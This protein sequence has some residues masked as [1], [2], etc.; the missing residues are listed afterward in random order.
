MNNFVI[1]TDSSSNITEE[2]LKEYDIKMLPYIITI[3]G[4][5]FLC[6]EEGMDFEASVKNLYDSIKGGAKV[7][8]TLINGERFCDFVEPYLKEGKDVLFLSMSSGV[9]GTYNAV[10]HACE[11]LSL[12]Y[13]D[14]KCVA[15]DTLAASLGEGLLVLRAAELKKDGKSLN[16]IVAIV[17]EE[18]KSIRQV[19]TVD[20]LK[21]LMNGGR[22]SR[23]TAVVGT[24]LHIKPVL[25]GD[26]GK[27]VSHSKVKG[28]KKALDSLVEDFIRTAI[29]PEKQTVA[30]THFGAK[31]DA[32]Y[33]AK[34]I[35]ES[36]KV[37]EFLIRDYD[38]CTGTYVG[39]GTVAL[40]FLGN[41]G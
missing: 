36:V 16:E 41:N 14:R 26:Q 23:L 29:E 38:M 24:L 10:S 2:L 30:L 12:K 32:E 40:F 37:K 20:D 5:D 15:I 25:K 8:T 11:E 28:R 27:I 22:I 19:F 35:S 6:Y 4:E 21:Y 9:S 13:P 33:V 18:K 1:V 39:P 3:D 17:N 31:E 34:R 7:T